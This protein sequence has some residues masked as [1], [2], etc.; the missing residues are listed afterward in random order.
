M[1]SINGLITGRSLRSLIYLAK[2]DRRWTA[3]NLLKTF[4]NGRINSRG[5]TGVTPCAWDTIRYR[6]RGRSTSTMET[7]GPFSSRVFLIFCWERAQRKMEAPLA[8]H[9]AYL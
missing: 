6:A 5:T 1:Q 2:A 3:T 7:E 8:P 4:S 9:N